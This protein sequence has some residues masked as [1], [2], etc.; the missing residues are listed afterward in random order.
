MTSV[1]EIR[2]QY[3]QYS[4]V[5]DGDLLMGMHKSLYP[6]MHIK[7]FMSAIEGSAN[8]QITITDPELKE[9]WQ[10][11][12]QIPMEG[13]TPEQMSAR[14]TGTAEGP[15]GDPGGQFEAALRSA[16]QGGTFGFGEEI[17][18]AGAS[19]APGR[20]YAEELKRERGRLAAGREA[21][22]KTALGAELAGAVGTG[23][24]AG[25]AVTA[26]TTPGRIGQAALIGTGGG[27]LYGFGVGEGGIGERAKSAAL[28]G[29]ISGIGAGGLAAAGAGLG[30]GISRARGTKAAREMIKETPSAEELKR[31]AGDLYDEAQKSGIT[32]TPVYTR[33][34][35]DTAQNIAIRE[36]VITPQGRVAKGMPKVSDALNMIDDFS[37]EAMDPA[38]MR[39]VRKTLTRAAQSNDLA[40][41][42]IGSMLVREF[43]NFTSPMTPTIAEANKLYTQA[44]RGNIIE[45]AV[46]LA[47][48]RAGQ[49]SGSGYEN[50]LRT[51]FRRL[52]RDIIK[53]R[54][55]GLSPEQ[56]SAINKVAS[57][58]GVENVARWVGR[59]APTSA[60]NVALGGGMPYLIGSTI[61][62]P[63]VGG[64][65]GLGTMAA[66]AMGRS[67]ATKMQAQNAALASALM[68]GGSIAS[69]PSAQLPFMGGPQSAA[70]N[71]LIASLS[72]RP[73]TTGPR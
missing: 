60:M 59:A 61:G 41:S 28:T 27:A 33:G 58:G 73:Q 53:G 64:A 26:A 57:G 20:T 72:A 62:G 25:P 42:R 30:A 5:S 50:A 69:P 22:P 71:A 39:S 44:M 46:D 19:L 63:A 32:A 56:T 52:S 13:E 47:G 6:D 36:G 37:G 15:V 17:V 21:Y 31:T 3:P 2:E 24:A 66:G 8:A 1:T 4:N 49:F 51:E 70:M 7:D 68:R 29:A 43:D 34:F 16:L 38:Q 10:E 54:L 55:K 18:A 23:L 12:A 48:V 65:A 45:E 14:L 9:Y 35:S 67:A 11:R 40:E